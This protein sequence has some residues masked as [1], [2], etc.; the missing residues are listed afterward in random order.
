MRKCDIVMKGGVT[1][2]IVYPPA[3]RELAEAFTFVNIGGTSAG[4][5]A[6]SLTAAAEY[7]RH[8]D[9]SLAGFDR[10]ARVPQ[11]LAKNH[12]LVGLFRPNASTAPIFDRLIALL[13]AASLG[14]RIRQIAT[15]PFAGSKRSVAFGIV[16]AGAVA[17]SAELAATPNGV[18]GGAATLALAVVVAAA[19][20]L[21]ATALHAIAAIVKNNYGLSSGVDERNPHDGT[22]LGIWLGDL[23][24]EVAGLEPGDHLTFGHLW[25][26]RPPTADDPAT[27]PGD[28][29]ANPGEAAEAPPLI[30]LEMVSTCISHGRPY[31]FPTGKNIFSFVPAVMRTYLHD[32]IVR[33]METKSRPPGHGKSAEDLLPFV[34]MPVD[35]DLPVVLAAR[36][37]L[38]FP[39][40]LTAVQLGAI[41][42]TEAGADVPGVPA[43]KPEPCWFADGGLSSNFPIHLFDS[44]LPRW[45]TFGVNLGS[46]VRESDYDP[47][48]ES[49]NVWMPASNNLGIVEKWSRFGSL[50]AYLGAMFNGVKDWNDNIQMTMPGFR[51]RIVTVKLR[52]SEGG[53]NLD[54]GPEKIEPLVARGRAAGALLVQRFATPSSGAFQKRMDWENHRIVRY[55]VA[56]SILQKFA[57]T[58]ADGYNGTDAQPGDATYGT[59]LENAAADDENLS[60][61]AWPAATPN[62][63]VKKRAPAVTKVIATLTPW[64]S[65]QNVDFTAGAPNP[66]PELTKR[67]RY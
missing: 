64:L 61:Y 12:A 33:L 9:G 50:P 19:V 38:A 28:G 25:F 47:Y 46:F 35:R 5:I 42:Y 24:D 58:F 57:K 45:P 7:R 18:A 44:P 37:S 54:M 8:R 17:A 41:D 49:K 30:N 53:L 13:G 34:R 59:L 39:I 26:G 27:R 2:G 67:P 23:L 36:M 21:Y 20:G 62:A 65:E 22:V 48:D 1:S 16:A 52:A 43:P 66:R 51:D 40:L 14:E 11:D 29:K 32:D 55:R 63:M 6:A 3:V 10:L 60:A 4:A 56:M 31:T 15:L